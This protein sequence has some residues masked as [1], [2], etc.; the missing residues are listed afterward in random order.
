MGALH[1]VI[2]LLGGAIVL[3]GGLA[4]LVSGPLEVRVGGAGFI[5]MGSFLALEPWL[6]M[7]PFSEGLLVGGFAL[8]LLAW[9]IHWLRHARM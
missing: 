6:T 9:P 4:A 8:A 5:L 3:A 2:D 1:M 7:G